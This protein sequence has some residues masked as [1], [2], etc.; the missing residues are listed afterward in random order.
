LL[1][2][3]KKLGNSEWTKELFLQKG[4]YLPETESTRLKKV[5]FSNCN[6]GSGGKMNSFQSD[7]GSLRA[8]IGGLK[9]SPFH[10]AIVIGAVPSP[11]P[12]STTRAIVK[13]GTAKVSSHVASKW[14][15]VENLFLSKVLP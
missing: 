1:F 8:L 2:K 11:G 12:K 3:G 7:T 4:K 14:P 10:W 6:I 9:S 13:H 5:F 15:I